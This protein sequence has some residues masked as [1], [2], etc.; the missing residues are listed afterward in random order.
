MTDQHEYEVGFKKPPKQTQW[1]PGQ[2]GNPNGRP[3]KIK[4]FEKLLDI[5]LSKEIVSM[6]SDKQ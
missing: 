1:K 3:R 4:D 2:S 5:E 6:W